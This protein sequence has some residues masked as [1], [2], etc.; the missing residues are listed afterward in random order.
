MLVIP[1]GKNSF[2]LSILIALTLYGFAGVVAYDKV[3]TT[4]IRA[5]PILFAVVFLGLLG[6]G[7]GLALYGIYRRDVRGVVLEQAGLCVVAGL[8]V[9]FAVWAVGLNGSRAT[10]F[11]VMFFAVAAASA[12]R[13]TEIWHYRRRLRQ[14]GGEA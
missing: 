12:G 11:A 6:F 5:F 14:E 1:S 2:Q 10:A 8:S 7:A 4:T 9:A 3:A 13:I